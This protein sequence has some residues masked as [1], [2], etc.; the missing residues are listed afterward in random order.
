MEKGD[1]ALVDVKMKDFTSAKLIL[2]IL[3]SG[4]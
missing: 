3:E 4:T 2:S 1:L